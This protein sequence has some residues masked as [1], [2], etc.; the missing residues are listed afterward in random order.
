MPK[1]QPITKS[2][3]QPAV[4]NNPVA[5]KQSS[6]PVSSVTNVKSTR[7][8]KKHVNI[9]AEGFKKFWAH[10]AH[11]PAA[12]EQFQADKIYRIKIKS[13]VKASDHS[14]HFRPSQD[15]QVTGQIANEIKEYIS[16]ALLVG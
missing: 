8:A 7:V 6:E 12:P 16:H 15:I 3:N 5:I 4:R 9:R 13:T 2:M 1:K 14:F 11:L 10:S